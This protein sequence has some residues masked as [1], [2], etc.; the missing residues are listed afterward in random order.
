MKIISI[1]LTFIL[2]ALS[3]Q[4]LVSDGGLV[5]V[6]R[7]EQSLKVQEEINKG[8]LQRNNAL[9]AEVKD[10]RRGQH[11]LEERARADLGMIKNDETFYQFTK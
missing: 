2:I 8:L 11:A 1:I 6:H 4:L 3:Y 7:I 5:K 10:L 9:E